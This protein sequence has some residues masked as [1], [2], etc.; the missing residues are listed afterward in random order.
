MSRSSSSSWSPRAA[1]RRSSV[2]VS[3]DPPGRTS[4]GRRVPARGRARVHAK[5]KRLPPRRTRA[6]SSAS[7]R[8]SSPSSWRRSRR[9]NARAGAR[10]QQGRSRPRRRR[11]RARAP[12]F[13]SRA[14]RAGQS[15]G[16]A[17][18]DWKRLRSRTQTRKTSMHGIARK[19]MPTK[20]TTKMSSPRSVARR[21]T[22]R[23]SAPVELRS[24]RTP[25]L[26]ASRPCAASCAR[27]ASRV[28][29]TARP[30]WTRFAA[31]AET[32]TRACARSASRRA[33]S[34]RRK[35]RVGRRANKRADSVSSP[36]LTRITARVCTLPGTGGTAPTRTAPA[37][38][39]ETRRTGRTPAR[40]TPGGPC[41]R[42]GS[43]PCTPN[44][45]RWWSRRCATGGRGTPRAD[46]R[47]RARSD[48]RRVPSPARR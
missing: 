26:C 43:S 1:R 38:F 30:L 42:P 44:P 18:A 39:R 25:T 11:E 7:P 37:A 45:K 4:S 13:G 12:L 22:P 27:R 40:T 15:A 33:C 41:T 47:R 36:G 10:R 14:A 2:S 8:T 3:R 35:A 48:R 31:R 20:M 32:S 34:R 19:K 46:R 24:P 23:A 16:P 17:R 21:A 5:T 28:C 6:G 9:R 29:G